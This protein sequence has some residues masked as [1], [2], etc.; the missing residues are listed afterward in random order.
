MPSA[1]TPCL[2]IR[3]GVPSAQE[4]IS[5]TWELDGHPQLVVVVQLAFP[6]ER[7]DTVLRALNCRQYPQDAIMPANTFTADERTYLEDTGLWDAGA[8]QLP[9]DLHARVGQR[10]G[11][12]LLTERR[13]RDLV[14]SVREAGG[15]IALV[16]EPSTDGYDVGAL[17]WELAYDGVQPW[18]LREGRVLPCS[19]IVAR[20][21][22]DLETASPRVLL[23]TPQLGMD[24]W[25]RDQEQLARQALA[26]ALA[27]RAVIEVLGPPL[28]IDALDLRLRSGPPVT[29]IDYF[30][31]GIVRDS[32]GCLVFDSDAYGRDLVSAARLQALP[33]VPPFW[34]LIACESAHLPIGQEPIAGIAPALAAHP[35]VAAVIGM[36]FT[37]RTAAAA[38]QLVP[39]LYEALAHGESLQAAVAEARRRAYVA[40]PDS[41]SFY[42]PALYVRQLIPAPLYL[43]AHQLVPDGGLALWPSAMHP[44][45]GRGNPFTP[46]TAAPPERFVG[47]T[48]ELREIYGR[49]E[50]MQTI[51]LV[52]EARIGKTSL[53]RRI[54]AG[55][56]SQLAELGRYLPIYLSVDGISS[57]N[58]F[59]RA[60]LDRLLPN[61][62]SSGFEQELRMLE[63]QLANQQPIKI[64]TLATALERAERSGLRVVLLLDE[65]RHLLDHPTEFDDIFRNVLRSLY[66]NRV[67]ALLLVTR[68]PLAEIDGLN[69][70]FLN[71]LGGVVELGLLFDADAEQ[72]IGQPHERPFTQEECHLALDVG[73]LHPFRLQA[74]GDLLYRWKGQP[75]GPIYD[76]NGSLRSEARRIF[77][78]EVEQLYQQAIAFS[79]RS[80]RMRAGGM[81]EDLGRAATTVG[82]ASDRAG[83]RVLG[84]F[85]ILGVLLVVGLMLACA[86]GVISPTELGDLLRRLIGGP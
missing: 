74:A 27:G 42:L 48:H 72:L 61:I 86:V 57:Q 73:R 10:L 16:F 52:G 47:R 65:F 66:T 18:L 11:I 38:E 69:S 20:E 82:E 29:L 43:F 14:R 54:E 26:R 49:L 40:E 22:P 1:A 55:L 15:S 63:A 60:I 83:N 35:R 7:W 31:H 68:Q 25:A 62:P 51:S 30:G 24:G 37:T 2:L 64:R 76:Q 8:T 34:M 85:M 67:A 3:F 58:D 17:P 56:P 44:Q 77:G 45:R 9:V 21:T 59:C 6:R 53:L 23:L 13:V 81:L 71:G 5:T 39:A 80:P 32:Q 79:Q 36:Q 28:T 4:T 19:R 84:A 70:Y 12:A 75:L 41:A 33:N 78:R 50:N 46:G